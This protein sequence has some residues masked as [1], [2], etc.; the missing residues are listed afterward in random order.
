M[1]RRRLCHSHSQKGLFANR[2]KSREHRNSILPELACLV[3]HLLFVAISLFTSFCRPDQPVDVGDHVGDLDHRHQP[4]GKEPQ[5]L[6]A[7]QKWVARKG[8]VSDHRVKNPM[9]RI[10]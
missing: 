5:G 4:N 3:I 2:N 7:E 6:L 10:L 9:L 1:A 8:T